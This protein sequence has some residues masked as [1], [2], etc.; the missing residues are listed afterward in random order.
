MQKAS[1]RTIARERI[2]DMQTNF[3][4]DKTSGTSADTLLAVGFA[5]Y[6][7]ELYLAEYQMPGETF[8][9]DEGVC[10]RI[11]LPRL[12]DVETVP[13][14]KL[15]SS[16]IVLPLDSE[17]QR[18]KLAKK[19]NIWQQLDGFNYD[20][21]IERSQVHRGQLKKLGPMLQTP[22]ARLR[23]DPALQ[24]IIETEPDTRLWHYLA[25]NHM[26]IAGTFN[27]LALRWDILTPP[28]KRFH[29]RLLFDLFH[30]VGNDSMS[31]VT[32]WREFA[33]QH[34][35]KGDVFASALQIMNPTT[36][37]GANRTKG[38]ELTIGNQDSFWLLELLKFRG[39]M[40]AAAPVVIKDSDDRK[41][42]VIQPKRMRLS[43]LQDVMKE[44]RA[45]FWPTTAIKLDILASLR[46]A[47][48][49][50]EQ[51]RVMFEHEKQLKPWMPKKPASLAQEF[52]VTFYKYLGSAHATMN[53]ATIALP[54]WLTRMETLADVRAAKA[55]LDEHV[56]LIRDIHNNKDEEGGEE[57]KLLGYYRDFLSGY[58]LRP[59]W[60]FT[61]AYSNY[62]VSQ[63]EKEKNPKRWIRQLSYEGLETLIM[64]DQTNNG[65]AAEIVKSKGFQHIADAIRRSTVFA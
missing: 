12:L 51:Y 59:F 25:I 34:H 58:D 49:L 35:L 30:E 9:Y 48:V 14:D 37:K 36:G 39:F 23:K 2:D 63:R 41:T 21:E 13:D 24:E 65:D 52:A 38:G 40:E 47:Q 44:F 5:S 60:K 3:Y 1:Q 55:L 27:D 53:L 4:V 6:L 7:D 33:K 57:Y 32:R 45:V 22:D 54:F 15:Q 56:L 19:G 20:K 8:L 26:K 50:V 43:L 16:L 11:T 18:Q 62:M 17:R 64:S 28:Q 46:F 31:A 42:Y 61:T 10:Y 29:I